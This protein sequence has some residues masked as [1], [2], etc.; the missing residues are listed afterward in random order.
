M[1]ARIVAG[2]AL[3]GL[4]TSLGAQS[5]A[6]AVRRLDSL[7]ASTYVSHDTAMALRIMAPT[8]VLTAS[9]GKL[10]TRADEMRDSRNNPAFVMDYFRTVNVALHSHPGV[11]VVTGIAEWAFVNN[12]RTVTS[13]RTYTATYARGGPM[14]WQMVAIQMG[15]PPP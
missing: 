8:L 7:W 4:V 13:R 9:D 2:V 5:P 3:A 15:T 11:V 6:D 1:I 14:G 10:K 12:G